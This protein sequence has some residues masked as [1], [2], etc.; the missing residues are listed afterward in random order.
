MLIL[1]CCA[2][3]GAPNDP[4]RPEH[5]GARRRAP[6]AALL[7]RRDAVADAGLVRGG[8][9]ARARPVAREL[10]QT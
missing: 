6:L 10:R 2:G 4:G 8:L 9:V 1:D 5:D 3:H 7:L